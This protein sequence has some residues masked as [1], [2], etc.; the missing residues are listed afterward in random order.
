MKIK[1]AVLLSLLVAIVPNGVSADDDCVIWV[2]KEPPS[3]S[4]ERPK[5]YEYSFDWKQLADTD[6]WNPE[7]EKLPID[8][9]TEAIRARSF[10]EA[11]ITNQLDLQAINIEH[12]YIPERMRTNHQGIAKGATNRWFIVF[13]FSI[14]EGED[15][16]AVSLLGGG[17]A[18]EKPGIGKPRDVLTGPYLGNN[19]KVETNVK[20]R[21]YD[22]LKSITAQ[23]QAPNFQIPAIQW[24]SLESSFPLDIDSSIARTKDYLS[25]TEEISEQ[26]LKLASIWFS[27]Y[28]P[29]AA[30]KNKRLNVVDNFHHWKTSFRY[31]DG[32]S[33]IFDVV[34]LLDG[35]ILGAEPARGR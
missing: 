28:I 35:T 34:V 25:K 30:I 22:P 13:E 11:T 3:L 33:G 32:S 6:S 4:P 17:Y 19:I 16:S 10:L 12:L 31:S 24:P 1:F 21:T 7:R 5:F 27:R 29:D 14:P 26:E 2:Q 15:R 8:L 18:Q 9:S 23:L 20:R